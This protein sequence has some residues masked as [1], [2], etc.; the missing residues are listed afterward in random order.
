MQHLSDSD[1]FPFHFYFRTVS[2]SLFSR[3]AVAWWGWQEGARKK[4]KKKKKENAGFLCPEKKSM[5]LLPQSLLEFK[6]DR[7]RLKATNKTVLNF[8]KAEKKKRCNQF[9]FFLFSP[10]SP[11]CRMR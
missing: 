11:E 2:L 9:S 1:I 7:R 3:P 8:S 4:K 5:I 6:S 10:G